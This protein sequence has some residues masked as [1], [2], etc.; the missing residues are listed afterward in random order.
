MLAQAAT[1]AITQHRKV[2]RYQFYN[3]LLSIYWLLSKHKLNSWS[4]MDPETPQISGGM[5]IGTPVGQKYP[6]VVHYTPKF[7]NLSPPLPIPSH[8]PE[9]VFG[10]LGQSLPRD[11]DHLILAHSASNSKSMRVTLVQ[12]LVIEELLLHHTL[13]QGVLTQKVFKPLWNGSL[14]NPWKSINF[15]PVL[16]FFFSA[17]WI[18]LWTISKLDSITTRGTTAIP[19]QPLH[20]YSVTLQVHA[21]VHPLPPCMFGTQEYKTVSNIWF[22]IFPFRT[23]LDPSGSESGG[24][25]SPS[26]PIGH[27]LAHQMESNLA[28]EHDKQVL[29]WA[30]GVPSASGVSDHT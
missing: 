11:Q 29:E 28:I 26:Y 14:L 7:M 25:S 12:S 8:F 24:D 15:I 21:G 22:Y 18:I 1:K 6:M 4:L 19:G 30:S 10:K 17:E 3:G 16:G 2:L 9:S 27:Y 13:S 5:S 20:G 23:A